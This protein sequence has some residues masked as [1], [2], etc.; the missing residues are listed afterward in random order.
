MR[1]K[2]ISMARLSTLA[3]VVFALL[4]I[5]GCGSSDSSG[6]SGQTS[7][8]E[9]TTSE[10]VGE[11]TSGEEETSSDSDGET[12][13]EAD[14][15]TSKA[16]LIKEGDAICQKTD[17]TQR[18]LLTAYEKEHPKGLFSTAQQK[19]VLVV[20]ALPPIATEIEELSDLSVPQSDE[21]TMSRFLSEM[22]KALKAAERDPSKLLGGEDP[23][24]SASKIAA[25]F[26]YK[27]CAKAG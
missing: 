17:E 6:T 1:R 20:V 9:A 10:Q 24:A 13:T 16:T 3:L 12:T 18:T 8:A 4:A 14:E 19:K 22:E 15:P 26:G 5:G 2:R 7:E 27:E 21:A 23:F 25:K 11:T